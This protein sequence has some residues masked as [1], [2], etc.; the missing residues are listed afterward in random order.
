M[1]SK[2]TFPFLSGNILK[3]IAAICMLCDHM[4]MIF[5]PSVD[6]FRWLGRLSFPIFAFFIAEGCR[7][8][9][10]RARYLL[11]IV[12]EAILFQIIYTA[13]TKD[14]YFSIFCTFSLS[15]ALIY[16]LDE[17]K[18]S[19]ADQTASSLRQGA[20]LLAFAAGIIAV[21]YL[22]LYLKISYQ[23]MGC[24]T[25]V[26][27]SLFTPAK[28]SAALEREQKGYTIKEN[29][30]A[31]AIPLGVMSIAPILYMQPFAL[32][33]IPLLWLYSGERGKYHCKYFF[34]IFYPAH[35]VILYGIAMLL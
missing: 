19:F 1:E 28:N 12:G 35:L 15:I 33:A 16:L 32:C 2:T 6:V 24:L 5:F 3:W 4:G 26:F 10:N 11:T 29:A 13:A 14:W 9:R 30:L 8:T 22:N 27:A 25:P 7:Y 21:Y 20:S 18:K 23:F 17:V 34:Y 31:M